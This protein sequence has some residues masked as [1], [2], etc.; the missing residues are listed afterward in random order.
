MHSDEP[1]GRNAGRPAPR[2]FSRPVYISPSTRTRHRVC[3]RRT[4]AHG[5]KCVRNTLAVTADTRDRRHSG[6]DR[7]ND[8]V[9][10]RP[11]LTAKIKNVRRMLAD[12]AARYNRRCH[13]VF[14]LFDRIDFGDVMV[15][16]AVPQSYG[17]ICVRLLFLLNKQCTCM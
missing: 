8:V 3:V 14:V 17:A 15:H 10:S 7:G 6:F 5:R 12:H 13:K 16:S 1:R 9:I 4:Y 2:R 11:G